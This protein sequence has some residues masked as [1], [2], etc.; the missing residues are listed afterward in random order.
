MCTHARQTWTS[1]RYKAH[2]IQDVSDNFFYKNMYKIKLYLRLD[3]W[4]P[5]TYLTKFP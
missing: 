1:I 5:E 3:F 2:I 4:S